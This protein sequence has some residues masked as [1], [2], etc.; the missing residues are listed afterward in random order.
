MDPD[1]ELS[2]SVTY[3]I[4][5][6]ALP[7]A[8]GMKA[9]AMTTPLAP[10]AEWTLRTAAA[11]EWAGDEPVYA[12]A[13]HYDTDLGTPVLAGLLKEDVLVRVAKRPVVMEGETWPRGTLVVTRRNNEA[14]WDGMAARI[15]A[16]AEGV[17][18]CSRGPFGKRHGRFRPRPGSLRHG[19]LGGAQGR[20]GDG[21]RG[22]V[23]ELWRG[24]AP[25]EEVWDYPM[26]AVRGL[27]W[28]DWDAYDVVVLP[29][30][31]YDV[32]DGMAEA[33]GN[34][35]APADDLWPSVPRAT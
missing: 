24:V 32:D 33:M 21:R 11:N 1:P 29:R 28:L 35:S 19:L 25:L 20:G 4:T 22:V 15:D 8:Y 2:D 30:G 26:T 10:T 7:Y 18:G 12:Y 17:A 16:L 5:T 14:L 13:I 6:W 9:Y 3:D 27:E 23:P 31:W 34:G